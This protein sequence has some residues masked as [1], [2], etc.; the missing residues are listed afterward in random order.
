MDI[1]QLLIAEG[2]REYIHEP[3]GFKAWSKDDLCTLP[4]L[5]DWFLV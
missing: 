2:F 1:K 4:D 5:K 3:T